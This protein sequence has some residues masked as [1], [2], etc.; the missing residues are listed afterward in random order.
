LGIALTLP[1]V[2]PRAVDLVLGAVEVRF[3]AGALL[4]RFLVVLAF[5]VLL[6][7]FVAF[8]FVAFDF[9]ALDFVDADLRFFVVLF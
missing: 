7:A 6:L 2:P 8:D 1:D 3:L 4:A 9:V 5:V